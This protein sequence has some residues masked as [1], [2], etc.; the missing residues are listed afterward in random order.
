[1][2]ARV[3]LDST[4]RSAVIDRSQLNVNGGSVGPGHPFAATGARILAGSGNQLTL[5]HANKGRTGRTLI[6]MCATGGLGV[7]SILEG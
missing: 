1:M 4:P 7:T 2:T 3:H 6:S 5:N